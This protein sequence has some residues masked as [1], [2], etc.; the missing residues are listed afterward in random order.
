MFTKSIPKLKEERYWTFVDYDG[1]PS[2]AKVKT[3]RR[4]Y[5]K[6]NKA[7]VTKVKVIDDIFG[8]FRKGAKIVIDYPWQLQKTL[9]DAM[10]VMIIAIFHSKRNYPFFWN[11]PP[12]E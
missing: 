7:T 11:K 4:W 5:D 10:R 8:K 1:R 12:W 2:I 3:L 9:E 6:V